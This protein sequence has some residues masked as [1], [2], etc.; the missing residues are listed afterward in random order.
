MGIIV[1]HYKNSPA[2]INLVALSLTSLLDFATFSFE[3]RT[4]WFSRVCQ[5]FI[6]EK[7][8]LCVVLRF[9]VCGL[10]DFCLLWFFLCFVPVFEL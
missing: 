5:E 2:L 6:K 4:Q 3:G 10:K 1:D 8:R 7:K 9:F